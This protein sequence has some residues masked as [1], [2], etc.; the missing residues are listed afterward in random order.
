M[1]PVVS[2]AV[3]KPIG[4]GMPRGVEPTVK[5]QPVNTDTISRE[6]IRITQKLRYPSILN[7]LQ[8]SSQ[9]RYFKIPLTSL[10][11]SFSL[12]IFYFFFFFLEVLWLRLDL[13][14]RNRI[15]NAMMEPM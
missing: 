13:Y 11:K 6:S 15:R 2:E 3:L 10:A 5:Q 8:L 7:S 4:M 12:V 14:A 9:P 1:K